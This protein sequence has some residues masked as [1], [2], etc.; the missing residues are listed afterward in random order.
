[1]PRSKTEKA[2]TKQAM[3]VVK[4][5]VE[6]SACDLAD[7]SSKDGRAKQLPAAADR[8][9]AAVVGLQGSS[10]AKAGASKPSPSLAVGS[11]SCPARPT[12]AAAA[13][14]LQEV[15]KLHLLALSSETDS[16][17]HHWSAAAVELEAPVLAPDTAAAEFAGAAGVATDTAAVEDAFSADNEAARLRQPT[18]AAFLAKVTFGRVS[19]KLQTARQRTTMCCHNLHLCTSLNLYDACWAIA[20]IC[21]AKHVHLSPGTDN[22]QMTNMHRLFVLLLQ[23]CPLM[24]P[25]GGLRHALQEV[26]DDAP[27]PGSCDA[28]YTKVSNKHLTRCQCGCNL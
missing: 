24:Q 17:R 6:P 3:A 14:L 5:K 28:L 22:Q 20:C 2:A 7:T 26:P 12:A 4:A 21:G 19:C 10:S 11:P 8:A 9:L 15:T 27:A 23:R 16:F 13:P 25:C 18:V 1:M